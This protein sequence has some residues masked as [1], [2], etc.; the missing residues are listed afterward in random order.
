MTISR[1]YLVGAGV[2]LLA[3]FGLIVWQ[4]QRY[5]EKA[6]Q[7]VRMSLGY[8]VPDVP[9]THTGDWPSR[10]IPY[11]EQ[12]PSFVTPDFPPLPEAAPDDVP[13]PRRADWRPEFWQSHERR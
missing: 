8:G 10:V 9:E 13:A 2:L 4:H 3:L 11:G 7:V 6:P 1:S 12:P 5:A